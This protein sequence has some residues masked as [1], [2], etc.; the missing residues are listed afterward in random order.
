MGKPMRITQFVYGLIF[1]LAGLNGWAVFFGFSPFLPT[2][3]EVM[4]F[5]RYPYLLFTEKSVE[6]AAGLLLMCNRW[7]PLALNMLAPIVVNILLF[8]LF[9]D[10]S[11]LPLAI[12]M[13]AGEAVL[14]W[15]CRDAFQGMLAPTHKK[16]RILALNSLQGC[17]F[18]Q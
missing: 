16:I 18:V 5:F 12:L 14:L 9:V 2:S 4:A 1:F 8:H 3:P 17:F 7:V 6:V 11:L 10:A 15:A 13:A